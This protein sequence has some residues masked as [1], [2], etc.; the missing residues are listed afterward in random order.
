MFLSSAVM[1]TPEEGITGVG[2]YAKPHYG[3]I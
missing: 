3:E 2:R 1:S